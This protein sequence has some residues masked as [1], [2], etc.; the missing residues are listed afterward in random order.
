VMTETDASSSALPIS[1]VPLI[2]IVIVMAIT[3]LIAIGVW[4]RRH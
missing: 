4:L 3:T 1:S 2:A